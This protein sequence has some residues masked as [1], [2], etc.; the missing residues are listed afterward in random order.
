MKGYKATNFDMSCRGF[1][2]ELNKEYS[3]DGKLQICENGFHFCEDFNSINEYYSLIGHNRYFEIEALGEVITDGNK[4]CTN[5]IEL[6][7]ELTNEE[8]AGFGI[9]IETDGDIKNIKYNG[10]QYWYLNGKYHR[11]DGPAI[12]YADGD[13]RWYK[14][15]QRHQ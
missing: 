15:G 10:S 12:I 7:R 8:L 4:S 6:I 14:N 5:K 1:Q 2:F 9:I 13:Q 3:V 11:E